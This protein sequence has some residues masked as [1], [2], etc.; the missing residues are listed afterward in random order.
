METKETVES[1]T[2]TEAYKGTSVEAEHYTAST[3]TEN[4]KKEPEYFA[5]KGDSIEKDS[6]FNKRNMNNDVCTDRSSLLPI[7][8]FCQTT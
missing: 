5:E 2:S 1:A 8:L 7:Q 4:R 6:D 3:E